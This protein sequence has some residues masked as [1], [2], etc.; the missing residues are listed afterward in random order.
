MK[1][2]VTGATGFIGSHFVNQAIAAGHDVT[3]LRRTAHSRSRIP[4]AIQPR[5][6]DSSLDLVTQDSLKG[7]ECIVHLAAHSVS[8]PSDTLENCLYWNLIA[9]L[10][11]FRSAIAEGI[12]HFVIAGSCFEY[13]LTGNQYEFIP[14]HA[15]LSPTQSYSASKAAASIAFSQLAIEHSLRLAIYRIFHVY[16]EGE[17]ENRLWPGLRRA[18]NSGQDF[19]MTSGEQVRDFIPVEDVA[20]KL[21]AATTRTDLKPGQPLVENL[22]SGVPRKLRDFAE[23]W[24]GKFGA[25]GKLL[26]GE[27]SQRKNEVMRYVPE[28]NQ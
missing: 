8:F 1:L 21:V 23:E 22:G 18:A 28:V 14:S 13:G 26:F 4:L 24:W 12:D 3:A 11:L 6:V 16:G 20:N 9:P 10:K 2:F 5:W 7:C 17:D 15:A 27:V 19:P 25:T